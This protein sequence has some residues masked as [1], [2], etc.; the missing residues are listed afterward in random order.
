MGKDIE[1]FLTCVSA[2]LYS[3]IENSLFSSVAYFLI[4]LFDVLETSFLSS[5]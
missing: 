4:E 1:H 5:S 2:I 3:S